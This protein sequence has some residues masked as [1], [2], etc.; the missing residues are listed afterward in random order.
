M[1]TVRHT[2]DSRTVLPGTSGLA[3]AS[4]RSMFTKTLFDNRRVLVVWALATGLLAMM[5]ASFYPQV[6]ADSA[7]NVPE[8]MSGFGFDDTASAAGYLQGAVFGLLVPL[9][10][11]FYGAATGARMVSADEESGYL[12]LLL[13]H[14]IG[15]TRLLLHR[16][17]ALAA[18]A[19]LIAAVVLL[20]VLAV[21]S[22]AELDTISVAGFAAQAVNLALLALV[23]GA[24][25]TGIG[26]ATGKSRAT[27]FGIAAGTGVLAYALN[28]FAPQ[29]GADWLRHLT[30][31]RYYI[32]GEP[33]KNGFQYADAGVLA[34]A[35]TILL[36]LG[37]WRF[38]RRD[39]GR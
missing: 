38:A 16:F 21:R 2:A 35:T 22:S 34:A 39:L 11:T 1:T 36:G 19:L 20:A 13:A 27:V 3:R 33:L 5:Y 10:A 25:A 14:P 12:D 29:I 9:L 32:G 6:T 30:P 26:A 18:G 24:L 17:A 7:A 4:G 23:F 37:A 28:G 15:R 8:A 31:F